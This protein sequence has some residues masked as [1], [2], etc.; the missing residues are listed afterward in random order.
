[1]GKTFV[2]KDYKAELPQFEHERE[3]RSDINFCKIT[4]HLER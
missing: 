3:Y 2:F 4:N 1:M